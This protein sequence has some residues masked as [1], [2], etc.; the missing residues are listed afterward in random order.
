MTRAAER[1]KRL[2]FQCAR[3]QIAPY[4]HVM[5]TYT[6]T[7]E[8]FPGVRSVPLHGH[9]PGHCGYMISSGNESL[10]I[11]GDIVHV[12]EIQVARPGVTIDHD[13]DTQ[14]AA[15][16]RKRLFDMVAT[17][18]QLIAGMHVHFPG[19]A[20]VARH[21]RQLRAATGAMGSG[22]WQLEPRVYR[23]RGLSSRPEARTARTVSGFNAAARSPHK[24]CNRR[25]GF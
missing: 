14:A 15:M 22:I 2:Y 7:V 24:R 12:P 21:W 20:Y 13:T 16:T 11:W 10:L 19:F 8:V 6:G 4:H 5:N 17:D 23:C 3:E 9:T 18:R 25:S 1:A